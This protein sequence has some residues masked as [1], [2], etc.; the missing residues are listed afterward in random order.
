[1]ATPNWLDFV[2]LGVVAGVVVLQMF[3]VKLSFSLILYETLFLF[4]AG[5]AADKLL[6]VLP[7]AV[8]IPAG[9]A[10]AVTFVILGGLGL[11]L[12]TLINR[13][14]EFEPGR[15]RYVFGFV[16]A[17]AV[18]LLCAHVVLKEIVILAGPRRPAVGEALARSACGYQLVHLR[19][20]ERLAP[21]LVRIPWSGSD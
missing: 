21:G 7:A 4:G 19:F 13:V 3:R 8:R 14:F 11:I 16:F 10:Y 9:V 17:L 5:L 15:V 12:A 6:P 20:L 2:A 1:V 18:G